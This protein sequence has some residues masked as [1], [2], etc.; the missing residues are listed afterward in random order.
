MLAFAT[1]VCS[2]SWAGA[3]VDADGVGSKEAVA[4]EV[5]MEAVAVEVSVASVTMAVSMETASA[6]TDVAVAAASDFTDDAISA[7]FSAWMSS[8]LGQSTST[9]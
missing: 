4:A 9:D 3:L 1:I 2:V 8:L 7:G 6:A 5:S